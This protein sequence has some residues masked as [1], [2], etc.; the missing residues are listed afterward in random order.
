M[1]TGVDFSGPHYVR[2]GRAR[3]KVWISVFTCF[4]SRAIHLELVSDCTAKTFLTALQSLSWR[5]GAPRVLMSD[6][7]TNFVSTNKILNEIRDLKEVQDELTAKGIEWKFT[8]P[9]APWYGA[10][11]ERLV[12]CL[13][14][15]MAK[16]I[17][18]S[19]MTHFELTAQLIE[20]EGIINSRPLAKL[21]SEDVL[22]TQLL[23]CPSSLIMGLTTIAFF[24]LNLGSWECTITTSPALGV[25]PPPM[26]CI[27]SLV[28]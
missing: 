21:G 16:L 18:Q 3:K 11:Y 9:Y 12:Q 13:K 8:P 1:G 17:G 15:E 19:E 27:L 25:R 10:I 24:Q 14:R 5:R 7:Q 28:N 20:I 23:Q 22:I 2:M 26:F 4:V 6:N